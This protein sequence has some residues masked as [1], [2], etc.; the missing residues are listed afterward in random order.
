M[1]E[2]AGHIDVASPHVFTADDLKNLVSS[3]AKDLQD[4]DK[5]RH[6]KFKKYELHKKL[7]EEERLNNM[8]DAERD[9]EITRLREDKNKHKQHDPVNHPGSKKQFE[10]VWN[11][12]DEMVDEEFDP[13]TFFALHDTNSDGMWD[14]Y[15]VEA[16][17]A[18][19][20]SK[21][22]DPNN[23]RGFLRVLFSHADQRSIEKTP[24]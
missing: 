3:A 10:E 21:V 4:F 2:A 6:E 11:E 16:L 13:K 5:E 8:T 12:E 23:W 18:H 14:I 15:E 22:Y 20:L 9:A 17:M 7:K 24:Q 1:K 19:E